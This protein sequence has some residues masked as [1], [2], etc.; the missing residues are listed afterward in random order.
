MICGMAIPSP[1]VLSLEEQLDREVHHVG[2]DN[3]AEK[4]VVVGGDDRVE[5]VEVPGVNV[6]GNSRQLTEHCPL[7]LEY[8]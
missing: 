2:L 5:P 3:V 6:G 7:P 8:G 4:V 1:N